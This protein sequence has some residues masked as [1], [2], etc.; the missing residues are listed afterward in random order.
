MYLLLLMK[1]MHDFICKSRGIDAWIEGW[2]FKYGGVVKLYT[3]VLLQASVNEKSIATHRK[4]VSQ[5]IYTGSVSFD[6]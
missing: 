4:N 5:V 1:V 3:F 6:V 2:L